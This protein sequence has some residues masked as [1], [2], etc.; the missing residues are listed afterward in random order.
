MRD[1]RR[2]LDGRPVETPV[3]RRMTEA[4]AHRGPDGESVGQRA[5]GLGHHGLAIIDLSD[6]GRQ[7]GDVRWSFRYHLQR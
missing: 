2:L 5:C 7:P 3:V 4:I 1:C 6:G